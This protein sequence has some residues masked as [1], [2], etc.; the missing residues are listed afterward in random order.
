MDILMAT[1]TMIKSW[2]MTTCSTIL[3]ILVLIQLG[4]MF[5]RWISDAKTEWEGER[6]HHGVFWCSLGDKFLA[7]YDCHH[8]SAPMFFV[9]IVL[10]FVAA[11]IIAI[12]WQ[13]ILPA[14]IIMAVGYVIRWAL[15][16]KRKVNKALDGKA[17]VVHDH[18][19]VY[20]P[21]DDETV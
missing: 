11:C 5:Y 16:F 20:V 14:V 3:L 7:K 10:L 21:T 8:R 6:K 4:W 9:V 13:I 19:D 17:N 1:S 12:A 18:D 2:I 15:R